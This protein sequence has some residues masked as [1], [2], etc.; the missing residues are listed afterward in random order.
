MNLATVCFTYKGGNKEKALLI[1]RDQLFD[2]IPLGDNQWIRSR[3]G[4][5]DE[6]KKH[7]D[8]LNETVGD[9]LFEAVAASVDIK[10]PHTP[11]HPKVA[12]WDANGSPVE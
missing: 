2:W 4:S 3:F 12:D 9:S 8:H 1:A 6:A 11:R 7:A 5:M 10:M